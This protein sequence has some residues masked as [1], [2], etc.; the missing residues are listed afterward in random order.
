M[1]HG[2]DIEGLIEALHSVAIMA[3]LI[4]A[5]PWLFEPLLKNAFLKKVLLP[6]PGDKTG[7]GRIMAVSMTL[8]R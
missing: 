6:G 1:K 5:L 2:C 4:A 7:S 8:M 3:G